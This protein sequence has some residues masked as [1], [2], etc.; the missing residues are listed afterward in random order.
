M[1][2]S[3]EDKLKEEGT[4]RHLVQLVGY[5]RRDPDVPEDLRQIGIE[6][7]EHVLQ[8][9]RS[10]GYGTYKHK[11]DGRLILP[12]PPRV[13]IQTEAERTSDGSA[14]PEG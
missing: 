11:G 6:G 9:L 10:I 14:S 8:I 7:V 12:P 13:N 2:K 3:R 5:F 4:V 1:A